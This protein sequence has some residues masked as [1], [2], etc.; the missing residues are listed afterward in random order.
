[1]MSREATMRGDDKPDRTV[2]NGAA[3]RRSAMPS[4]DDF[5]IRSARVLLTGASR[6]IGPTIARALAAEGAELVLVA[7]SA[8]PLEAL[9][10]ELRAGGVGARALPANLSL[11]AE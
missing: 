5:A 9:A 3:I 7:R 6:G 1:M 10:A 8:G 11:V 4:G 2:K